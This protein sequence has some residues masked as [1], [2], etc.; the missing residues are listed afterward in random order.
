MVEK[1]SKQSIMIQE[2]KQNKD[3]TEATAVLLGS[4]LGL[5]IGKQCNQSIPGLLIGGYVA[6]VGVN[7]LLK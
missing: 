7:L 6:K 4:L 3:L 2:L 1:D 5:S